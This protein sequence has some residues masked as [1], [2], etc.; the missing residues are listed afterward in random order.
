MNYTYTGRVKRC[1][2]SRKAYCIEDVRANGASIKPGFVW[3][4]W[5]DSLLEVDQ[6]IGFNAQYEKAENKKAG[7]KLKPTQIKIL[8]GNQ[9]IRLS[10]RK[11]KPKVSKL[12]WNT[13]QEVRP[14]QARFVDPATLA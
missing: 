11:S 8:I 3:I 12:A 5:A 7:F 4:E 6:Y 14:C 13:N 9:P 1:N 10:S 2:P